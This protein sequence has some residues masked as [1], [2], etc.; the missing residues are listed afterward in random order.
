M[1]S[2]EQFK[3]YT[4]EEA[5]GEASK[6]QEK[7]KSGE[8]ISYIEAEKIIDSEKENH[9]PVENII[10]RVM[11]KAE[12]QKAEL[13]GGK[14]WFMHAIQEDLDKLAQRNETD[15]LK[16]IFN[17]M[18]ELVP[19]KGFT[20]DYME[21]KFLKPESFFSY[22]MN[23]DN[24]KEYAK[25]FPECFSK[26]KEKGFAGKQAFIDFAEY[27]S[28]EF[29]NKDNFPSR[30]AVVSSL[31]RI[32]EIAEDILKDHSTK[33]TKK[34][35]FRTFEY[36]PES[37]YFGQSTYDKSTTEKILTYL[38]SYVQF[39]P[40]LFREN[41]IECK[42]SGSGDSSAHNL[43]EHLKI[44]END[45]VEKTVNPHSGYKGKKGFFWKWE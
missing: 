14:I 18:K 27:V 34:V 9:E 43:A 4:M 21:K 32:S 42:G 11:Q 17:S 5:V 28:V 37:E 7:I 25:R 20:V 40:G 39:Q 30:G 23:D 26:I 19:E 45:I 15:A 29:S 38:S 36:N 10:Q 31:R 1:K 3:P 24:F 6:M 2:S 8:A 13:K 12:E 35:I 41:I 22:E 44:D 33:G 16:T